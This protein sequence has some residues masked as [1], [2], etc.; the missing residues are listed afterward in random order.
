MKG[1]SLTSLNTQLRL[2][3]YFRPYRKT[4]ILAIICTIFVTLCTVA[5]PWVLGRGLIG[6][7]IIEKNLFLLK[8]MALGLV[9]LVFIKGFFSY[10][11]TYFISFVGYKVITDMR[12][13]MYEHLQQLSLSFFK[14]ERG[15]EIIS[16][17]INDIEILQNTLVNSLIYLFLNVLI[18]IGVIVSIFYLDWRLSLLVILIIP[19]LGFLIKKLGARINKFS[20]TVQRKI[21]DISS[22]LQETVSGMEVIKSFT[23]EKRELERFKEENLRNFQLAMKRT[24]TMALLTPSIEVL[25]T[26][27]IVVILWYG[28]S[29]VI[30]GALSLDSLITFLGCLALAINPMNQITQIYSVY[31]RGLASAKRIFEILDTEP[32]I[33]EFPS[34][35]EMPPIKGEIKFE[36]VYFTYDKKETV[37]EDINLVIKAG[38]KVALVGESGVG[39]STMVSLIPRFYDPVSGRIT[40][41]GEDIR[42]VKIAT[43]RRQISIVPQETILFNTTILENIRYGK[44]EANKEEIIKAAKKANAHEFIIKLKDGYNTRVGERGAKLSGGERQ[45]IAIARAILKNPQILILDEATSNVDT[46]T[47]SLIKEALA[48]LMENRTT[49]I[50]AHRLFSIYNVDRILVLNKKRIEE[51]GTHQ[52]LLS[53]RGFYTRLYK[54]QFN[55]KEKTEEKEKT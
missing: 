51:M 10:G 11:Q 1:N 3:R 35:K 47:E 55:L 23:L 38:E 32:T 13:Q 45:R 7:V 2:W 22:I 8:L 46:R 5:L 21:A 9:G 49:I 54:T 48:R 37:L 18:L 30:R 39:K 6:K 20:S 28:A 52:E 44:P 40:I 42:K 43:L 17:M 25:S 41:D 53:K 33:K 16:R 26:I 29:E 34:A 31:Q 12:T 27:A 24:Q 15:G 50:I 36:H 14:R 4:L 19:L